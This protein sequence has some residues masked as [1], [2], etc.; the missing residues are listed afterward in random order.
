MYLNT[1]AERLFLSQQA[2]ADACGSLGTVN[3]SLKRVGGGRGRWMGSP[4][5]PKKS[6]AEIEDKRPR[7]ATIL[8]AGF[9]MRMVPINTRNA[10]RS[11]GGQR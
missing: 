8:A 7:R 6:M 5:L 4:V 9:G 3:R 1:L 10:E 2:R 11:A